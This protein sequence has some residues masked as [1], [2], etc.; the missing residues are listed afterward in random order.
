ESGQISVA[1]EHLASAIVESVLNEQYSRIIFQI[2]TNK[3]VVAASVEN[4]VHQIGIKMVSDIF[5]M[6]GFNVHYLGANNPLDDLVNFIDTV[7]PNILAVSV[8]INYHLNSLEKL[9]ETIRDK[10]PNLIIITGGQGLRD[11]NKEIVKKYPNIMYIKDLYALE[12][13][14]KKSRA[15]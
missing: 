15:S 3:T 12:E 1:S 10:Y 8:S 9:I 2:K 13:F 4:E 7:K 11:N 14:L 5:E 6:S